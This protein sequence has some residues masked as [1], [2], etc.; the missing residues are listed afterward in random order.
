M[1]VIEDA[2]ATAS[3]GR[4]IAVVGGLVPAPPRRWHAFRADGNADGGDCGAVSA[5]RAWLRDHT[6]PSF[7]QRAKVMIGHSLRRRVLRDTEESEGVEAFV[8]LV[9]AAALH[10]SE[11]IALVFDHIA[12]ADEA[13]LLLLKELVGYPGRFQ[14]AIVLQFDSMPPPDAGLIAELLATVRVVEGPPGLVGTDY[15][16]E[17]FAELNPVEK[18]KTEAT[19]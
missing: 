17:T 3:T 4:T 13:S 12:S 10:V 8:E 14:A 11:P 19:H 1:K 2:W 7:L 6:T 5:A 16:P 15:G 9:N 18:V